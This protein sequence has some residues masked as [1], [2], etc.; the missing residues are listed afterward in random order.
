MR[1]LVFQH[2]AVEHPGIFRDLMR[3][4]GIAWD[5]VELDEGEP[6]PSLAPYDALIVMGGPMDVFDEDEL[7]WLAPEKA[8]IREAVRARNMPYFGFCLGHQLLADS[9]G[10]T[11]ERMAR[12]EVGIL[13]VELTAE[14]RRDPLMA[15]IADSFPALQWHGVAV[16]TLPEGGV[17]LAQS[18]ACA[19]QAQRVGQHA[20]GVQYHVEMTATTVREWA[21]VPAYGKALDAV[22]GEGALERLDTA[23]ASG[24]ADF[25]RASRLLFGNFLR[26]GGLH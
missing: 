22:M 13:P 16:T 21:A 17:S 18:P 26:L 7:P 14:G 2:I 11:C 9:L 6:I 24:M 25:N 5:A 12:P 19:I 8:A 4:H 1:F 20:C 3:E 10:G 15:G 23:C